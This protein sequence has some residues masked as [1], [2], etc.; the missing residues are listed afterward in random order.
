MSR[1]LV[2]TSGWVYPHWRGVFYPENLREDGWFAY[3]AEHFDTVEINNTF[4]HLPPRSTFEG[5]KEQAPRGFV[6]TVKASRYITHVKKLNDPAQPVARFYDSLRGLGRKCAAVLF[7]LPPRF[8]F[9]EDRLAG[10]LEQ[11][12]GDYRLAFEFRDPTW[13]DDRAYALLEN[14]GAALAFAD[15]RELQTPRVRTADFTFHRMHGGRGAKAPGYTAGELK[16][17]AGE[18]RPVLDA[19][20]DAFVYFNND[21]E[22]YALENARSL[23]EMLA[24]T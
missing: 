20:Q 12:P 4:Y 3:Y 21:Y 18:V 7:Q 15:L 11:V 13:F 8:H 14:A 19:G 2:G 5:W 16:K 23:R 24:R 17:L 6:Y 22:G 1:L 9:R 10:L